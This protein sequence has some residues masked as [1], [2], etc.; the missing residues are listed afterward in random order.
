MKINTPGVW[1]SVWDN[2]PS[3]HDKKHLTTEKSTKTWKIMSEEILSKFKSFKGLKVLEIGA[4]S[5]FASMLFAL[6]GAEVTV[7]DYSKRALDV[8]KKNFKKNGLKAKF[9]EANALNLDKTLKNKFDISMSFGLAEHFKGKKR[10]QIIKS[11][12][13]PLKTG[14]IS[15]IRVPNAYCFPYRIWMFLSKLV[16]RWQFGLEIPFT[17]K[18]LKTNSLK[19]SKNVEVFGGGFVESLNFINPLKRLFKSKNKEI[20]TPFDQWFGYY[21]LL[22]GKK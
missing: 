11:H 19:F 12:F 8:A 20:R 9:V 1:D 22:V 10:I 5:G 3:I 18:E 14:G 15:F 4:G 13:S 21:L 6:R 16:G 2:I 17:H 7:L